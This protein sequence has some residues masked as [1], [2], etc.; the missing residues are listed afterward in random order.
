MKLKTG[1]IGCGKVADFHA[2]AYEKL[3]TALL[4]LYVM[5]TWTVQKPLRNVTT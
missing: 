2:K 5:P 3:K 4:L 1:I